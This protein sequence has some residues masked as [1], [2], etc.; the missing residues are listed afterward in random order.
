MRPGMAYPAILGRRLDRAIINLGFSGNGRA[1]PEMASFLA[2]LD[3]AAYVLDCLPNLGGNDVER[4]EVFV[5]I[6]RQRH[7]ATPIFLVENL[8]YP[9]GII[10]PARKMSYEKANQTLHE[11]YTRL[12]RTDGNL[13]YFPGRNL[14][15]TDGEATVDG[16]HPTDLGAMRM[17]DQMEPALRQAL[18]D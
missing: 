14:I 7:P 16:V 18:A 4:L 10:I 13:H 9:D 12:S 8:E 17:A 15:G 5:N 2:E 6:L 3:P 1:E 11:I